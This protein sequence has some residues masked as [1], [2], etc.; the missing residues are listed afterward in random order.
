VNVGFLIKGANLVKND[1]TENQLIN[2][3]AISS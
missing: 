3:L 2:G 1:F